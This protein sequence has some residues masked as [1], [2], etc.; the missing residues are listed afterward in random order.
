MRWPNPLWRAG[1]DDYRLKRTASGRT[2]SGHRLA[3]AAMSTSIPLPGQHRAA[4]P[5][6]VDIGDVR[7]RVDAM[8]AEVDAVATEQPTASVSDDDQ[9]GLRVLA[10]QARILEQAHDVLVDAL[11]AVDKN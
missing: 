3:L 6:S 1:I 7:A 10:R 9:D 11:A 2:D 5:S 4:A 8:L